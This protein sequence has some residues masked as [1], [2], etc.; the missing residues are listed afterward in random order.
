MDVDGV[1]NIVVADGTMR[2]SQFSHEYS[3]RD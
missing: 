3:E 1:V 2:Q